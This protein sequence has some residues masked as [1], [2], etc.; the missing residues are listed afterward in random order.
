M[1]SSDKDTIIQTLSYVGQGNTSRDCSE[2]HRIRLSFMHI[3]EAYRLFVCFFPVD[4]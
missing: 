3:L 2:F 4:F 1:G